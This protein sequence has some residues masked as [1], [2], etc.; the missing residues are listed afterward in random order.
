MRQLL[1]W[2]DLLLRSDLE[3]LAARWVEARRD[4]SYLLHGSRLAVI[5]PWS[6]DHGE[7]LGPVE[8]E[9]LD[10]SR[11]RER[12]SFKR[13]FRSASNEPLAPMGGWGVFISYRRAETSD[14]AEQIRGKLAERLGDSRVFLDISSIRGGVDFRNALRAAIKRSAVMLVLIGNEW[15]TMSNSRGRRINDPKDIVRLEIEEG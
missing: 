15:T 1:G 8:Q 2:S 6:R 5:V 7:E 4:E 14:L 12:N 9:F 10:A 3:R 11:A 13:I